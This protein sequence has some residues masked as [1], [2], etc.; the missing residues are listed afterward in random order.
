M[1]DAYRISV[2]H[3][4][5]YRLAIFWSAAKKSSFP[6][7]RYPTFNLYTVSSVYRRSFFQTFLPFTCTAIPSIRRIFL[8]Y[9]SFFLRRG[10]FTVIFSSKYRI[11][12]LQS[13]NRPIRLTTPQTGANH[14]ENISEND[15]RCLKSSCKNIL[16]SEDKSA[17][18]YIPSI[19]SPI[20]ARSEERRVGKE[21]R[22][23]WSPDH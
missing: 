9:T 13:I 2:V 19:I 14:T 15:E 10:N 4:I 18:T 16:P 5:S 7:V 21:C 22:S 12:V 11:F 1:R 3:G 17:A 6:Q 20:I 8:Q 23:R